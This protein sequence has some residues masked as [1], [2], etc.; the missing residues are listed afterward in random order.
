MNP[1]W[2]AADIPGLRE[3]LAASKILPT[4][5]D[6]V[7][8]KCLRGTSEALRGVRYEVLSSRVYAETRMHGGRACCGGRNE[9]QQPRR[10]R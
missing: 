10:A 1:N 6:P 9:L 8:A 2:S 4:A 5:L 7:V 3:Y